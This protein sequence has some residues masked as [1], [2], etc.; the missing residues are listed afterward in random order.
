MFELD[1]WYSIQ[2]FFALSSCC[3]WCVNSVYM[4][5]SVLADLD[6]YI[7][8]HKYALH[9]LHTK[10]NCTELNRQIEYRTNVILNLSAPLIHSHK[11][12]WTV[13]THYVYIHV[14]ITTS[15][16]V[17]EQVN[18]CRPVCA[19]ITSAGT[20][21]NYQREKRERKTQKKFNSK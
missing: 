16:W 7:W 14:V 5:N 20:W 6:S 10:L 17:S 11:Y 9:S 19:R 15:E 1:F 12:T 2:D 3:V 21:K 13:T 4:F 8:A 18:I